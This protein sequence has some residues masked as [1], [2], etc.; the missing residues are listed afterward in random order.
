MAQLTAQFMFNECIGN[1]SYQF[2]KVNQCFDFIIKFQ[3][4]DY[5][6]ETY[7]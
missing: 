4:V 2:Q 1:L 6:P 3:N 7:F 5:F